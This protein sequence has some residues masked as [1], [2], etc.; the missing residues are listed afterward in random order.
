VFA[1]GDANRE[2]A[3]P[4]T[5]ISNSLAA[6][7]A[8]AV[9]GGSCPTLRF[10]SFRDQ[11]SD[12][13]LFVHLSEYMASLLPFAR[14]AL[15]PGTPSV[16]SGPAARE[17]FAAGR[18]WGDLHNALG[19]QY[20][21]SMNFMHATLP[22][23]LPWWFA[24]LSVHLLSYGVRLSVPNDPNSLFRD[25]ASFAFHLSYAQQHS[26]DTLLSELNNRTGMLFCA[27]QSTQCGQAW[28]VPGP[29]AAKQ[30]LPSK[31]FPEEYTTIPTGG[32]AVPVNLSLLRTP[33]SGPQH[34][35]GDSMQQS[36][37]LVYV[38]F[39]SIKAWGAPGEWTCNF[40]GV[41][42]SHDEG[43]T[44][45]RTD[46]LFDGASNFVQ[47]AATQRGNDMDWVYL[48][49]VPSGRAGSLKLARAPPTRLADRSQ[50]Q[51]CLLDVSHK[52]CSWV[53][54]ETQAS[55]VLPGPLDVPS[56]AFNPFLQSFMLTYF[57][58]SSYRIEM[59]T[60]PEPWG[61]FGPASTLIDCNAPG[62]GGCYGG[63][64]SS[65]LLVNG[66]SSFYFTLSL[67][68]AYNT[69]WIRVDLETDK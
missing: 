50:Y 7:D 52:S 61:P 57:N 48:H 49:G 23:Q 67:W 31:S 11:H 43:R 51:F 32:I 33:V 60:A 6:I 26:Q 25:D 21:E 35:E 30:A 20:M 16:F 1:F 15:A 34:G 64:T 41:A 40:G 18:S 19:Q 24:T 17:A 56:A 55:V 47:I 53:S 2:Q 62:M 9:G 28:Q 29:A 36:Q 38:F 66:G 14:S 12:T 45:V 27:L 44:F 4:A 69:F 63:F 68:P 3:V 54:A 22:T 65:A 13:S 58:Q 5:D 8:S 37:S 46:N 42:T 39:M 59:R 10:L